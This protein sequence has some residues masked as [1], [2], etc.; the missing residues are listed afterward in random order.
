MGIQRVRCQACSRMVTMVA[1]E[2]GQI[3]VWRELQE[4][5]HTRHH[6]GIQSVKCR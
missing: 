3:T 5:G 1:S 4:L 2:M 6:R